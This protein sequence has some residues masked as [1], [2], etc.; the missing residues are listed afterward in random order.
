MLWQIVPL[1]QESIGHQSNPRRRGKQNYSM[2]FKLLFTSK[3]YKATYDTRLGAGVSAVTSKR[4]FT[5]VSFCAERHRILSF[6]F[7]SGWLWQFLVPCETHHLEIVPVHTALKPGV[8]EPGRK[9][10]AGEVEIAIAIP[11]RQKETR[12]PEKWGRE[13]YSGA[14]LKGSYP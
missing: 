5:E 2:Y 1:E 3:V 11:V 10:L 7:G 9:A 4:R 6:I 14:A 8:P 12:L 13:S